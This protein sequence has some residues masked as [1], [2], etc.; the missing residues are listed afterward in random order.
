MFEVSLGIQSYK[1]SQTTFFFRE[2]GQLIAIWLG[3]LL[4]FAF[5]PLMPSGL[6]SKL[7]EHCSI[8]IEHWNTMQFRPLSVTLCL[9]KAH[10]LNLETNVVILYLVD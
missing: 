6:C 4:N 5:A 7:T 2:N 3:S 1:K 8:S 10:A 9:D